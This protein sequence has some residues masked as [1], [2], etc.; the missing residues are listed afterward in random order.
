MYL[1]S[2]YL[3][4]IRNMIRDSDLLEKKYKYSDLTYLI[5]QEFIENHYK[6]NLEMIINDLFFQ[7]LG[8]NLNYNPAEKY[9]TKNIAP[10]EIDEY[11]RYKEVHG[12]VHDM[13]AAMF[14]GVS[15]HAGLFGNSINV[16]KVMQMYLQGGNYGGMQIINSD[17]ID[18]FNNCYYCHEENR[19][20]VGFDKPQ[21]EEDGP[22]CGCVSMDSFGH[23]GWTGTF[24]WTDPEKNIVY[25]FLSNRSYPSGET[26]GKS[27]LVK[28]NIRSEI[29]KIIYQSIKE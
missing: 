12:Y 15:A 9:S 4:T 20:G 17:T 26:A 24:T 2:D 13:A 5:I 25:V 27:L 22:T 29:Q 14:G 6:V 19:R 3:D 16:A 23:S 21:L 7:K 11:F 8:I 10:T 1:K 28:E 18:L